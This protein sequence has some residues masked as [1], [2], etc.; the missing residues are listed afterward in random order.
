MTRII[1]EGRT[2]PEGLTPESQDRSASGSRLL[3]ELGKGLLRNS[4][5]QELQRGL[6]WE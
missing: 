5:R 3:E 2:E 1:V 4:T 6:E